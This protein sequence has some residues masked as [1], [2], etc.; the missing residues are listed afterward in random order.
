MGN[1]SKRSAAELMEDVYQT[2]LAYAHSQHA[3]DPQGGQ[4]FTFSR[5]YTHEGTAVRITIGLDVY[6]KGI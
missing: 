5:Q 3:V 4:R 1:A 6:E 2:L